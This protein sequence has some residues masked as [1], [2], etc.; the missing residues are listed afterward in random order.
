MAEPVW[1]DPEECATGERGK[2]IRLLTPL[3][4]HP[5]R[6]ALVDTKPSGKTAATAAMNLRRGV[7]RHP[8][9]RWEFASR[10]LED[11]HSGVF[12]RYLG[13]EEDTDG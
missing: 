6:W 13:P 4:D 10:K 7:S 5:K 2:W 1:M 12:A 11:G 8:E 3:M 9:G